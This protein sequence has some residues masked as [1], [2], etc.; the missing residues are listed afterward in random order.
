MTITLRVEGNEILGQLA[1]LV[2]PGTTAARR[3]DMVD[4][5][6]TEP[7]FAA[8]GELG[9][10]LAAD[11]HAYARPLDGRDEQGKTRFEVRGRAEGGRLVPVRGGKLRARGR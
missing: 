8:A 11:P 5:A 7:L 4:G 9:V 1:L 6:L 2:P 3:D 10:V